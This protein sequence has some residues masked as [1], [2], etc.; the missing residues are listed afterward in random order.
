MD[1]PFAKL[2][3][4]ELEKIVRDNTRKRSV[5]GQ[6]RQELTFRSTDRENSYCGRYWGC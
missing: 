5:L 1:R 6:V 4:E 2:S 3:I